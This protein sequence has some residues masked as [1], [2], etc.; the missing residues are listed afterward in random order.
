MPDLSRRFIVNLHYNLSFY[1]YPAKIYAPRK[2][3][4]SFT[5]IIPGISQEVIEVKNEKAQMS[6]GMQS[7]YSVLIP[8]ATLKTVQQNWTKKLQENTKIKVVEAGQELQFLKAVKPEITAD[9]VCIYSFVILEDSIVSLTAFIQIDSVFFSPKDDKTD[10]ATDK[11]DNNIKN[12][13]KTFAVD[14]YRLAVGDELEAEQK[15]LKTKENE[16]EKLEKEQSNLEKDNSSLENDID[17]KEREI[18]EI[19]GNIDL[20]SREL[21]THNGSM[22]TLAT[23][24]EKKAAKEKQKEIEKEKNQLEKSRSK[25]KDD[26]SDYKSQIEKNNKAI[27]QCLEDQETKKQEIATQEQVVANVQAKL[28]GIK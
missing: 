5:H 10:L 1:E 14:Q 2:P 15:T 6:K 16:L 25:A 17:D 22:L 8:Q 7:C 9:T 28:N 3:F 21:L 12:Y 19:E 4:H 18:K 23:E 11:I 13:I 20:K 24:P 26:V 27:E